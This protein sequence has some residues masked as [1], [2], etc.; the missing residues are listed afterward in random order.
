MKKSDLIEKIR[1]VFDH[2]FRDEI[3]RNAS[4]KDVCRV[5]KRKKRELK[6]QLEQTS[7]EESRQQLLNQIEIVQAQQHKALLLRKKKHS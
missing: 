6:D 3:K 4:L 5:L 1:I 7:D 2:E